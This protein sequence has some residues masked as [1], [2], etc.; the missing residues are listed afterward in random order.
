FVTATGETEYGPVSAGVSP[1]N[2]QVN[3]SSIPTGPTGIVTKRGIYRTKAGGSNTGPFYRVAYLND[4]STT[5]Y[6]DNIADGSL[7]SST[8]PQANT[9]AYFSNADDQSQSEVFGAGAIAS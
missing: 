9:T 8:A 1:A 2:Q 4:N 5:T 6:T 3:L 7:S